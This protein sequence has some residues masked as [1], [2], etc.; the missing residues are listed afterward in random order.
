[1]ANIDLA[2]DS[3][4]QCQE[5]MQNDTVI[6]CPIETDK[7]SKEFLVVVHN[8]EMQDRE[9]FIRIL[10]PTS[11]FQAKL[12]DG[13][14]N[15]F[16]DVDADILEYKHYGKKGDTFSDSVMYIKANISS[17]SI[18]LVKLVKTDDSRETQLS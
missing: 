17:D 5:F 2:P 3:L 13:H 10:L 16:K 9:H 15:E 7:T 4:G 6:D 14:K 11:S 12:W 1:M 8:Q 18:A